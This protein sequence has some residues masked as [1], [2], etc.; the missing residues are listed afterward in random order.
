M[1]A[2]AEPALLE[3]ALVA[4]RRAY[5]QF[6]GLQVIERPGWLQLLAP[7]RSVAFQSSGGSRS[8]SPAATC[9]TSAP[10]RWNSATSG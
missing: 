9:W 8:Q 2:T 3:E 4:P 10:S 6:P 1:E 5:F 7:S